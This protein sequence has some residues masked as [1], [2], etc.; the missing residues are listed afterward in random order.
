LTVRQIEEHFDGTEVGKIRGH[1]QARHVTTRRLCFFLR[2]TK[3]LVTR[4]ATGHTHRQQSRTSAE[5]TGACGLL[6]PP[7]G[8]P[9]IHY[10]NTLHLSYTCTET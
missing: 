10:R 7:E 1:M 6:D 3:L 4:T 8:G 5:H 9:V 2:E